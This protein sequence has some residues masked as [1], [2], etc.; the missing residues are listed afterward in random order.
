MAIVDSMG[1][2]LLRILRIPLSSVNI[3]EK[4][5]IQIVAP[6]CKIMVDVGARTDIVF[7]KLKQT[8]CRVFLIEG[9]AYFSF[10]C[11]ASAKNLH[12]PLPDGLIFSTL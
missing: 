1:K 2:I 8:N 10:N 12:C 9:S 6:E 3:Y 4:K 11:F 7:A 5:I